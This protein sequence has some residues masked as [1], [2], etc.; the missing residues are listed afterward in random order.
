M[1]EHGHPSAQDRPQER[2]LPLEGVRDQDRNPRP[3]PEVSTGVG[4]GP[5]ERTLEE[6]PA[7]EATIGGAGFEI[8][9]DVANAALESAM[10]LVP[11]PGDV[12]V[13]STLPVDVELA[14]PAPAAAPVIE[15][16]ERGLVPLGARLSGDPRCRFHEADFFALARSPGTGFDPDDPDRRWH[17][18]LLDID[19]SPRHL[20]DA[21]N[22]ALYEPA[23]LR[24]LAGQLL[25]GG[26]FA[27]W[28]NDPPDDA[29][30]AALDASF[31]ASQAHRVAFPNPYTGGEASC[32]VYVARR[33]EVGAA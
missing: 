15:W 20:L 14:A 32:T 23:G 3:R 22:A 10:D 31:H 25:P 12:D 24:A 9:D 29:F 21:G 1:E 19:H 4:A 16:H 5:G 8:D 26:V 13:L 28:S 11:D 6:L 2:D 33:A 30:L 17:A 27:M 18:V 7:A